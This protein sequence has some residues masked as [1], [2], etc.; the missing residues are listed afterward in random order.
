MAV[1]EVW[2]AAREEAIKLLRVEKDTTRA[3]V[4]ERGAEG[5]TG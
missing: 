5:A 4:F 2:P 1:G 3:R